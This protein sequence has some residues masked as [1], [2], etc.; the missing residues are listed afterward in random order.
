MTLGGFPYGDG[1]TNIEESKMKYAWST[2]P[3][4]YLIILEG[5]L[6]EDAEKRFSM[7]ELEKHLIDYGNKVIDMTEVE[8]EELSQSM[9]NQRAQS[10]V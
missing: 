5:A 2:M 3:K 9:S 6:Q 4:D 8:I 1:C 10:Y 7:E